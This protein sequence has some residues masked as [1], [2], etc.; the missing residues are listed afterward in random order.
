MNSS[1]YF[2]LSL[3]EKPR[4]LCDYFHEKES[5]V[6]EMILTFGITVDSSDSDRW[7]S[8]FLLRPLFGGCCLLRPLLG[9][10]LSATF[11]LQGLRWL[12]T[13]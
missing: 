11:G 4:S 7:M 13:L 6:K 1:C 5:E 3:P 2:R 12:P 10:L 8:W 9:A